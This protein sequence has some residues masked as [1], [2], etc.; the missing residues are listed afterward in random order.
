MPTPTH[1][2]LRHIR[3]FVACAETGSLTSAAGTLGITQPAASQ[4][5]RRLEEFLDAPLIARDAMALTAEGTIALQRL[6]RLCDLIHQA[7]TLI[8]KAASG[9]IETRLTW[10]H[11]HAITGFAEHGSFSA[12]ARMLELSEPA[13][14]RAAREAEA[15]IGIPLFEN[16]GRNVRLTSNGLSAARWFS[17]TLSEFESLRDELLEARNHYAGRISIGTL[18]LTRTFLVPDVIAL[19]ANRYPHARFE[20]MEG[21]YEVLIDALER[22][23]IDILVGALRKNLVSKTLRQEPLFDFEL[24]IVGRAD[25]PLKQ[26]REIASK[27]LADYPWVVARRDTPSRETFNAMA[28]SF[29][30]DKPARQSIETGSLNAIRG[31]LLKSDHLALLSR[32]QIRYE[33]Q[34]G[35]LSVINYPL[36]ASRRPVGVTLRCHWL[37]TALQAEFLTLL[38]EYSLGLD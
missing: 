33:L 4:A 2:N 32:H 20:I 12:A 34:A 8:A 9:I 10:S 15:T 18:P 14:Q 25:H 26:C 24:S 17:L 30:A 21:S 11:L 13:V 35:F 6:R 23:R 28:A 31:V 1:P 36:P 16:S 38:R 19:L 5:L 3:L 7:C 27:D 37:P 29:P 22:G